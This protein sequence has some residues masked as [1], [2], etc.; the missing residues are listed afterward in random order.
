MKINVMNRSIVIRKAVKKDLPR[1]V[2]IS[3]NLRQLE[4][5]PHQKIGKTE[6][7]KFLFGDFAF[8]LVAEAD[9]RVVGYITGFRSDDYFFLPFSAV[10][11]KF[12]RLGI[13]SLLIKKVEEMAHKEKQKY[14]LCT[15]YTSNKAIEKFSKKMGYKKSRALVQYY[16]IL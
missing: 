16:K 2:E 15:A 14:I 4:N 1:I 9:K 6:F 13:A 8:M 7:E 10:D 3:K 5:Y 12:R 11:K